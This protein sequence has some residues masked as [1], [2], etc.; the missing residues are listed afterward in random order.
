MGRT[1]GT[2]AKEK[3][4]YR[5]AGVPIRGAQIDR[6]NHV[7]GWQQKV[8]HGKPASMAAPIVG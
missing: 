8:S 7:A 2:R 1:A 4:L 5:R 6:A 3:A